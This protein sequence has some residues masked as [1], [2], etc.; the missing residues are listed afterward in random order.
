MTLPRFAEG[1]ATPRHAAAD[2]GWGPQYTETVV[3]QGVVTAIAFTGKTPTSLTTADLTALSAAIDASARLSATERRWQA[4]LA[5]GV[6]DLLY[7]ARITD[8]PPASRRESRSEQARLATAVSQPEI[9]RIMAAYLTTRSPQLRP[10]SI[11]GGCSSC[12]GD[13]LGWFAGV[14]YAHGGRGSYLR[15]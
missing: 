5:N 9:R 13:S 3:R 14:W 6:H 2:L 7:Q 12:E 10:G 4:K 8:A 15:G 1:F 11:T